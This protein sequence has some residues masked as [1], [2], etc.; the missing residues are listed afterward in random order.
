MSA[1]RIVPLADKAVRARLMPEGKAV[2]QP[3]G[4]L[5]MIIAAVSETQGCMVVTDNARDFWGIRIVNPRRQ[6][7]SGEVL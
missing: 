5:E 7:T 3:H 2:G 4:A 1:G 6:S